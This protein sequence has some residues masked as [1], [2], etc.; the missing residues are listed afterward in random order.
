MRGSRSLMLALI[1]A[2]ILLLTACGGSALPTPTLRPADSALPAYQ[3]AV[4]G[5]PEPHT[6]GDASLV[7]IVMTGSGTPATGLT[8]SARGDM[9]HAGM[10]PVLGE[11]TEGDPGV[12]TIPWQWTM[13]GDWIVDV[14]VRAADGTEVTQTV[15]V[16][17]ES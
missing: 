5:E 7:V 9:T 15:N 2:L 16:T 8:V 11:G 6:V 1:A 4:R 13:A 14:T 3:I 12:Y 10:A 17:V